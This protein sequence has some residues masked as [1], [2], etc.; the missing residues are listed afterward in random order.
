LP[1]GSVDV[2]ALCPPLRV[3]AVP[4]AK[5]AGVTEPEILAVDTVEEAGRISQILKL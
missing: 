2:V 3:S 4:L 1:A 5:D